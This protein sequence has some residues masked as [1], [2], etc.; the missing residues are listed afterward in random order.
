MNHLTARFVHYR[1]TAEDAAE[2][3]AE[4]PQRNPTTGRYN[5]NPVA[6]GD[7]YPALV[8]AAVGDA[9][10]LQV[11]LDGACT[12]WA[13]GR[14]IGGGPGE[15]VWAAKS[16]LAGVDKPAKPKDSEPEVKPK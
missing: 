5:R 12:W 9:F 16:H 1:L 15:C 10:N 14:A 11:F 3:E 6:E 2:I 4:V 13:P 7:V 8:V